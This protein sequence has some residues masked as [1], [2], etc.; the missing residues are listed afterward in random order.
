VQACPA[1][2]SD[3]SVSQ[4]PCGS[5]CLLEPL[6]LHVL[7]PSPSG[8]FRLGERRNRGGS[9]L[10]GLAATRLAGLFPWTLFINDC[11]LF[12]IF[13]GDWKCLG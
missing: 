7:L 3:M 8:V 4:C 5:G 12:T 2:A 13:G 11:R 10:V 6:P 9:C 1:D